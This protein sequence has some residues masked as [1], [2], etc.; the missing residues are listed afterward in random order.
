MKILNWE[1]GVGNWEFRIP[2]SPFRIFFCLVGLAV[3][4]GGV[5]ANALEVLEFWSPSCGPCLEMKPTIDQLIAEGY[6]LVAIDASS[7]P[8]AQE[9]GV[10]R[11]PC[12]IVRDNGKILK[13]HEGKLSREEILGLCEAAR[14]MNRADENRPAANQYRSR[15][16]LASTGPPHDARNTAEW[17]EYYRA[18]HWREW[19][20]NNP[21]HDEREPIKISL[22]AG[23]NGGASFPTTD[24]RQ[25]YGA[26][27]R[28]QG[29]KNAGPTVIAHEV[30]HIVLHEN[31]CAPPPRWLDEGIATNVEDPATGEFD[32]WLGMAQLFDLNGSSLPLRELNARTDYVDQTYPQGTMLVAMLLEEPGGR[33]KLI[34]FARTV[35]DRGLDAATQTCY[36][37]TPEQI[38]VCY[39]RWLRTQNRCALKRLIGG[40]W[41]RFTQGHWLCCNDPMPATPRPEL[42]PVQPINPP[43][44]DGRESRVEGR[45]PACNEADVKRWIADAVKSLPNGQPGATGAAGP[46]GAPGASGPPGPPGPPGESPQLPDLSN[47]ATREELAAAAAGRAAKFGLEWLLLAAGVSTGGAGVAAWLGSRLAMR[48]VRRLI[49]RQHPIGGPGGP[50]NSTFPGAK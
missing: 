37:K 11:V 48:G 17:A 34:D 31:L 49:E 40:V 47:F 45:E 28:W 14:T 2:H 10:N 44:V 29:G 39:R 15:N 26:E 43:L 32:R 1:L 20:G 46:A 7:D 21:P 6:P 12:F 33:Q 9:L 8:R 16:F 38:D 5:R 4:L 30:M 23:A 35:R 50:P 41:H 42:V 3:F 22:V 25:W 13:R 19:F 36:G 24:G 18:L 27:G